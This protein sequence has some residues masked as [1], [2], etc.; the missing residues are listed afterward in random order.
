MHV[1]NIS[2]NC[3]LTSSG[4]FD[5]NY[6]DIKCSLFYEG[7]CGFLRVANSFGNVFI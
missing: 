7:F 1:L 4:I 3:F 6:K 5:K 2:T